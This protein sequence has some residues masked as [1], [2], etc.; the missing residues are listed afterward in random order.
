MKKF[1]LELISDTSKMQNFVAIVMV[2]MACLIIL[3]I[4]I[5]ILFLR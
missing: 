2:L 4:G 1:I 5:N 3:G